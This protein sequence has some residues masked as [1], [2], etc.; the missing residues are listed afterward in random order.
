MPALSAA[1][2]SA[3]K[4][5]ISHLY[6]KPTTNSL[7]FAHA[8]SFLSAPSAPAPTSSIRSYLESLTATANEVA[9]ANACGSVLAGQGSESDEYGDVAV[10]L[11]SGKDDEGF[12][13]GKE[14]E[15]LKAL[16]LDVWL[17]LDVGRKE[18]ALKSREITDAQTSIDP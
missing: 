9:N 15:V 13:K 6:R 11:G 3:I 10:W 2:V 14:G 4:Q 5:T 17:G 7:S 8:P 1:T 18:Y 12:A 16:G